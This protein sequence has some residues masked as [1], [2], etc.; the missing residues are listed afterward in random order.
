MAACKCKAGAQC[1]EKGNWCASQIIPAFKKLVMPPQRVASACNISTAFAS[2]MASKYQGLKPYSPAAMF[3]ETGAFFLMKCKPCKLSEDTGSS[4][5]VT[6][7]CSNWAALCNAC[8]M[9]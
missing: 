7:Y 2:S 4:N 1:D 3:I 5:Q 9:V 8:L 6:P